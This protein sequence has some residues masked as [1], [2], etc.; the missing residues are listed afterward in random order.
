MS[1]NRYHNSRNSDS[2]F[3]LLHE[4][5][6]YLDI[7]KGNVKATY[8][9]EIEE[10]TEEGQ[11]DVR[12]TLLQEQAL[13][14]EDPGMDE[15]NDAPIGK[16]NDDEGTPE[17]Q[18]NAAEEAGNEMGKEGDVDVEE[19]V[20]NSLEEISISV[21]RQGAKRLALQKAAAT[22]GILRAKAP[23]NPDAYKKAI[24]AKKKAVR[25]G[26]V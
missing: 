20:R 21:A 2:V 13:Q 8:K 16:D 9:D 25:M 7:L 1:L 18:A 10:E 19:S 14:E 5:D 4:E 24:A 23:M 12:Q 22:R 3:K 15:V 6:S 17:Q 11:L 26:R